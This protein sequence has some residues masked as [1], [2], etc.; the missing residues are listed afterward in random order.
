M[1]LR[2]AQIYFY[3]IFIGLLMTAC[4]TKETADLLVF[5]GKIYTVDSAFSTCEAMVINEG[6]IVFTGSQAKAKSKYACKE[7]LDLKGAYVYPGFMDAHCH[8]YGYGLFESY[9]KLENT[10]SFDEIIE[11]LKQYAE[12]N[13]E[14]WIVGRGWDQNDWSI[15][16]FPDNNLLNT[17]F[18]DRPVILYRID[19]HAVLVNSMA[20]DRAQIDTI[21]LRPYMQFDDGVF[22]GLLFDNAA[23]LAKEAIPKPDENK[24]RSAIKIAQ[25]NCLAVGLTSVADAGLDYDVIEQLIKMDDQGDLKMRVYAMLN[26]N[27][28]NKEFIFKNGHIQKPHVHIQALKLYADGALGSRGACLLQDYSDDAGNRGFLLQKPNY[29]HFWAQVALDNDYQ[30]CTHAIGDSANRFVLNLYAHYLKGNNNKRWRI[31]HAQIVDKS[32]VGAFGKYSIIPSVQPTHATSDMYWAEERLGS[33][34]QNAYVYKDLLMQNGWLANGSDFPVES[35]NPLF[36]FYAAVSRKDQKGYPRD[37]FQAENALS[38]EEA[39][40]AMTIWAAKSCFEEKIKG[41]LE[42]GKLADFVALEQDIMTMDEDEIYKARVKQ[43]FSAG[44]MVYQIKE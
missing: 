19:G 15:K 40:R 22:T 2:N 43:T 41:S 36:G 4:Q 38:R 12:A 7:S 18:P 21:K 39:L 31:E 5:G 13:P 8:F 23:D 42:A 35:I 6:K 44:E 32:D 33:R 17:L 9:A 37:G 34:I 16:K 14:G 3:L 26:P 29:Y 28:Q 25:K 1:L 10:Q 24:I 27:D 20:F 30:L 11:I